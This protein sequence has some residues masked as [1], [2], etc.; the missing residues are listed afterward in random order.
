[1]IEIISIIYQLF[2]FLIIFS[3]PF[4]PKILNNYFSSS[5]YKF[6][7]ID[8]HS[9]NIIFFVYI[10]LIFSFSNLDLEVFFMTYLILSIFYIIINYKNY[11]L[12]HKTTE[13][14]LF[15]F[16]ILISISIFLYIGQNLKLEWDGA[17]HWLEKVLIFFNDEQIKNL[18]DVKIHA[19]YPHLGS[20]IWALFWKNSFLEFE[21]MGRLFQ[22]YFYITSIFLIADTFKNKN[23]L[24][25]ILLILFFI[26]V[27]FDSYLFAGYQEYLIFSTL[28]I[29]SKYISLI[30]FRKT[31]ALRIIFLILLILYLN[32]WFKDEGIVYFFLFSFLLIL[33]INT[34][35]ISKFSLIFLIIFLILLQYILQ[36]YLIGIYDFP[37]KINF[38]N[39]YNDLT[40]LQILFSKIFKIITHIFISFIKYPLWIIIFIAIFIKLFSNLRIDIHEKY[41]FLCLIFN[42]AFLISI[43]F[44]FFDFDQILRVSLDRLLFQTSGFYLILFFIVINNIKLKKNSVT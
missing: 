39:L 9:I 17:N 4:T 34:P 30:D 18:K 21:Y 33:T 36:K 14:F 11:I 6:K 37:Q 40:N 24:N 42:L 22:V 43:F 38:S 29:A 20:Y 15:F 10:C 32:C 35:L 23:Y 3:F 12:I 13:K 27:T 7:L 8:A 44:T 1:M 2:V 31:K 41:I 26:I 5:N 25:K 28:I 19:H 16:F